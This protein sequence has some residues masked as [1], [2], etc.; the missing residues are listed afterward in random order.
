MVFF[1]NAQEK[2][3]ARYGGRDAR[4]PDHRQSLAG[5]HYTME[6]VLRLHESAEP[7]FAP[8]AEGPPKRIRDVAGS[9][10]G[11]CM[12][13]HQVKET[14]VA[15]LQKKGKWDREMIWRYPLPEN[16]GFDL[17]IDRGNI[18]HSVQPKTSAAA[19]GMKPGDV[20]EQI[21]GMPVNSFG[22]AQFALDHAPATGSIEV[23]WRRGD[24]RMSEKLALPPGWRKT[25]ITWRPSMHR[26]MP[27]ARL[28]GED[29][30]AEE[31]KTLGL[32]ARQL[33]FRQKDFVPSQAQSA[34]VKA[35]DIILGFD[36]NPLEMNVDEFLKYVQLNYLVGDQ[37]TINLLRA[38]KPL[39]LPM[40]LSR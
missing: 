32:S 36:D 13:C 23:G 18:V 1:M 16:L 7:L 39:N 30:K 35:G 12:H 28:Y 8:R 6:S 37:V 34:G 9:R 40:T 5:L 14:L 21:N 3:Y 20:V 19:A 26:M 10:G 24:T 33:A 31:R 11:R 15:D 2:V 38:R 22:D 4:S 25:D 29:L 17:E 27:S